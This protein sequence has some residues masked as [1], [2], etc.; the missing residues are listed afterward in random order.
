MGLWWGEEFLGVP[1]LGKQVV[2]LLGS[3]K[4]G[5]GREVARFRA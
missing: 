1:W 3:G 4:S 5:N 2:E